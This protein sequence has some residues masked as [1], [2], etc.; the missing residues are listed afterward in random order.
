MRIAVVAPSLE[1]LGGQAILAAHQVKC[2][3]GDGHDV[4]FVPVNP[5]VSR[6]LEWTRAIRGVRTIVCQA[7]YVP[8][9]ARLRGASAVHIFSASYWSFLLAPVPAMLA[10]RRV[11]AKV[12]LNYHSGEAEDHLARWGWR[13]TPW[14]RLADEIVVS[15]HYLHTVFAQHGF[16]TT[17]IPGVVD[18][19]AFG[20]RDRTGGPRCLSVRN[21]APY[22]RIDTILRA[23]A[24]IHAR[25]PDATLT[26]AGVGPLDRQLRQLATDLGVAGEVRFVGRVEPEDVPA[27]YEQ[28]D[29]LLNT[30]VVDNQP[31]SILEA[32]SA[33][34]PVITTPTGGIAELVRNGDTGL[35]VPPED[36]ETTAAV[37]IWLMEHPTEAA[38]MAQRARRF[39]A[40]FT[41]AATRDS[42]LSIYREANSKL[43]VAPVAP[44]V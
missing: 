38:A 4:T 8:S 9:L 33:G 10:A 15:S 2:L 30:S 7:S 35:L 32:F 40:G 12:V 24:R 31:G 41:W 28:A 17:V 36:P 13:V 3:R 21:L 22:Y 14:L 43:H 42:W 1:C 37:A 25:H 19:S 26:I 27:L 5:K 11:G 23:F 44:A 20:F 39:V 18:L 6:P 29:L 16:E 34:L